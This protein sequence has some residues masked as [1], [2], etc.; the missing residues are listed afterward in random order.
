MV[1]LF[2]PLLTPVVVTAPVAAVDVISPVCDNPNA[3]EKPKICNDDQTNATENPVFGPNGILTRVINI[4]SLATGVVGV[5]VLI[6]GGT[7]MI[8]SGGDSNSVASA[9]RTVLYAVIS[10][11]IVAF[12]QLGVHLLLSRL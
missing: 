6:I 12:A 1:L 4:L 3:A 9:R 5:L 7:K 10:L 8:A 2:I 11:V